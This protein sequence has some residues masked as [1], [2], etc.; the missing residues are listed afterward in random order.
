MFEADINGGVSVTAHNLIYVVDI[1]ET[2]Y[3]PIPYSR[4]PLNCND[5]WSL[6]VMRS[7]LKIASS[8]VFYVAVFM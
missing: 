2:P 6:I 4:S 8:I 7:E 1:I 3:R 5:I